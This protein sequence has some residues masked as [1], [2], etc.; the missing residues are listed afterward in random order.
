MQTQLAYSIRPLARLPS[1]DVFLTFEHSQTRN[2][3]NWC[4]K[5]L[6]TK[7]DTYLYID[8][9]TSELVWNILINDYSRRKQSSKLYDLSISASSVDISGI[10]N[11]SSLSTGEQKK[12]DSDELVVV[13]V[14]FIDASKLGVLLK[15]RNVMISFLSN[16]SRIF[17]N[18]LKI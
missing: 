17:G 18:F 9:S 2:R 12:N 8:V 11:W 16:L 5:I 3:V 4:Y 14:R 1:V 6:S 15:E 10:K 7:L 13:V